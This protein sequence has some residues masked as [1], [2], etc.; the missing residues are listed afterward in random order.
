MNQKHEFQRVDSKVSD[1]KIKGKLGDLRIRDPIKSIR[2]RKTTF[3]NALK[4]IITL[5]IRKMSMLWQMKMFS[6]DS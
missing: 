1:N 3:E 6:V 5:K 4:K 2:H